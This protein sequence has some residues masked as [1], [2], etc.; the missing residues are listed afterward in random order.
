MVLVHLT[1]KNLLIDSAFIL[2]PKYILC[3]ITIKNMTFNAAFEKKIFNFD[4]LNRSININ[5]K[6]ERLGYE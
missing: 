2:S 6:S 3:K 1:L 4:Y 5:I